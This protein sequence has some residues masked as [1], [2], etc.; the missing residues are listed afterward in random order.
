MSQQC[1]V[2]ETH[3]RLSQDHVLAALRRNVELKRCSQ[4]DA[5]AIFWFY[6]Y[7]KDSHMGLSD[8]GAILQTSPTAAWN[9]IMG[10]ATEFSAAITRIKEVKST[11]SGVMKCPEFHRISTWDK[12]SEVCDYAA[13]ARKPVFIYGNSQI[14]KTESLDHWKDLHATGR[15]NIFTMPPGPTLG[16]VV[17][18]LAK[19]LNI[20]PRGHSSEIKSRVYDAIDGRTVM[21]FDE[22]HRAF[23]GTSPRNSIRIMEYIR[24]IFDNCK[25]GMVMSGTNIFREQLETGPMAPVLDQFRRRGIVFLSLPEVT[26]HAD[27]DIIAADYGL[28]PLR[29]DPTSDAIASRMVRDSGIGQYIIY[30]RSARNIAAKLRQPIAWS[31]FVAAFDIVAK[32]SQQQKGLK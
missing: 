4:T 19:M 15:V 24:S 18:T 14:G 20:P 31:H 7:A 29:S 12:I 9:I 13:A 11:V 1:I 26:P 28:P 23:K 17:Y 22:V 2:E 21:M 25:C 30:L 3:L 10:R 6:S 5:D 32:L 16:D 27:L 8:A